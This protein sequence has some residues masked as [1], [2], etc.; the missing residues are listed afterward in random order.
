[1]K[2][3]VKGLLDLISGTLEVE[4]KDL[5]FPV[6]GSGRLLELLLLLDQHWAYQVSQSQQQQ[7][8][9][10]RPGPGPG[11]RIMGGQSSGRNRPWDYPLCLVSRTG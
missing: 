11:G 1:M 6:D 2:D 10:Q 9:Q 4:G 7:Q 3:K 5:V 8:M